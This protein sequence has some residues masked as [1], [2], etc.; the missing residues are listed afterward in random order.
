MISLS[1]GVVSFMNCY[2]SSEPTF[3]DSIAS[4]LMAGAR[5]DKNSREHKRNELVPKAKTVSLYLV[6]SVHSICATKGIARER[7]L[8]YLCALSIASRPFAACPQTCWLIAQLGR[9][10]VRRPPGLVRI[11]G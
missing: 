8:R 9:P 10:T 7:D 4:V 1:W 3:E 6:G 11:S 2:V 5:P